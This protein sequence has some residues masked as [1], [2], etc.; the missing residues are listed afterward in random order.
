[1]ARASAL[2]LALL[3]T[4]LTPLTWATP[5]PRAIFRGRWI[6]IAGRVTFQGNW[7]AQ[8]LGGSANDAIG[9]WTLDDGDGHVTLQ[10]TW[11][12][13]K[14]AG[15]WRGRWQAKAPAGGTYAGT[16]QALPGP[17]FAG[18]TFED[19]LRAGATSQIGGT[20]RTGASSGNW[21]LK[22]AGD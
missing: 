9:S 7:S 5:A 20:W 2:V 21:W 22:T 10:G 6:A 3:L 14:Q 19:L 15:A 12:A 16:W 17:D 8:A 13:R 11:S 1:M 18:K 4:S